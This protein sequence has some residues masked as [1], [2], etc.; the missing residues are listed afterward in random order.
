MRAD[1][2]MR[3][4][5]YPAVH[6]F[7]KNVTAGS[8]SGQKPAAAVGKPVFK[9]VLQPILAPAPVAEKPAATLKPVTQANTKP[10]FK[11]V[12]QPTLAPVPAAE[13]TTRK[14]V[15]VKPTFREAP[16]PAMDRDPAASKQAQPTLAPVAED[17]VTT[18]K[19][20]T[21]PKPVFKELP[22][23]TLAPAPEKRTPEQVALNWIKDWATRS[24]AFLEDHNTRY[25][26]RTWDYTDTYVGDSQAY[27]DAVNDK[28]KAFEAEVKGFREFLNQNS[29]N[30]SPKLIEY[31]NQLL[32]EGS[33]MYKIILGN[34]T[35]DA[36][37]WEQFQ[38]ENAYKSAQDVSKLK[39]EI[40]NLKKLYDQVEELYNEYAMI[41]GSVEYQTSAEKQAQAKELAQRIF[42]L[43]KGVY[44]AYLHDIPGRMHKAL[45]EKEKYYNS[46]TGGPRE[47]SL[48]EILFTSVAKGYNQARY[49]EE[50]FKEM[51]GLSNEKD[52]YGERLDSDKYNYK[53]YNWLGEAVSNTAE[54]VGTWARSVSHPLAIGT[55][56]ANA[57]KAAI[58]GQV[59][60]QSFL[61]EEIFTVP[62][63]YWRG[64]RV[65]RT[66]QMYMMEAGHAYNE[67]LEAGIPQKTARR[68][69]LAVGTV[70]AGLEM[71]QV[72]ELLDAYKVTRKSGATPNF[73]KKILDELIERGVDVAAEVG[74]E[75]LQ[76]GVT[77]AGTQIGSKIENGQWAYSLEEVGERLKN[78]AKNAGLSFGVLNVPAAGMNLYGVTQNKMV[79]ADG[80][81][82]VTEA[83]G[84]NVTV[85]GVT[86]KLLGYD[87]NGSKVYQDVE[88]LKEQNKQAEAE[89]KQ[90]DEIQ[91][92]EIEPQQDTEAKVNQEDVA[93]EEH[94]AIITTWDNGLTPRGQVLEQIRQEDLYEFAATELDIPL[95]KAT[96]YVDVI[97]DYTD[98]S[99]N[100]YSEVRRYQREE[101]LQFLTQEEAKVLSDKIE[102]YI[103]KAPRWNGGTTFRGSTVSDIEL[104]SYVPGYELHM[105]GVA[106]WSDQESVAR[107][108]A[109]KNVT[110]DRP[111]S[112][113]YHC[114]T[115]GKGTGIQHISVVEMEAEVLCSKESRYVVDKIEI[116][117][118]HVYHVYLKEE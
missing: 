60:P 27:L 23:E 72:D 95:E 49:G 84:P 35:M 114:D 83:T 113:I 51:E 115:Q 77:I 6:V 13:T 25:A 21:Q 9:E 36:A 4:V 29:N 80:R 105:G 78:T 56:V 87:E 38:D 66:A 98:T 111:N 7:G 52:A 92:G 47:A 43:N 63:A 55:G 71:F 112:V 53:S 46:L 65:G 79:G 90:A 33:A 102:E 67:M 118:D 2:F 97:M 54:Q 41:T 101:P 89:F 96:E 3:T 64:S 99:T 24:D 103:Q 76:E 106:S 31:F 44:G 17:P 16:V 19:P 61:A 86:Y 14:P 39:A 12:P 94:N 15:N 37:Y 82:A 117:E 73:A 104:S 93:N 42:A 58:A 20:E 62:I 108:F 110:A 45:L 50:S 57:S 107:D 100:V 40:E 34:A 32:D 48:G 70:N 26:G 59:G 116:D 81:V 5:E 69:A 68:I 109:A 11:E 18:V 75:I 74:T 8:K 22:K 1:Q 10:V 30:L 88:V 28:T 91:T 85:D